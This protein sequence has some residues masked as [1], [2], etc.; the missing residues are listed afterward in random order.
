MTLCAKWKECKR[1]GLHRFRRNVVIGRGDVPADLLLIGEAPG[2]SEDL[3]GQPFIGPAGRLLTAALEEAGLGS[4]RKYITNT[5]A[6]RPTD[7]KGGENRQPSPAEMRACRARITEIEQGVSPRIVVLLGKV[8]AGELGR[9]FPEA[10]KLV[11]PAYLLRLGGVGTPAYRM[12]VREW[13]EIGE[14][15]S[16][17]EERKSW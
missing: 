5:V 8:A 16:G 15:L 12:F 3:Q 14:R 6:C 13:V 4:V 7:R 17:S 10:V 9:V 1:C 11:H 2:K